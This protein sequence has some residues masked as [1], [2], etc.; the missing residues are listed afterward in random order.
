M[1]VCVYCGSSSGRAEYLAAARR[2]GET[3]ARRG[4]EVVYGGARVGTM[5]AVA[6]GALAA[7]GRVIGVIPRSLVDWE[8]AHDG[9][10]ELRVVDTPHERKAVMTGLADAVLAL[11]G[12]AGTFDELFEAWTWAQLKLHAKPVGALN[13]A[14]Y[15]D[16]L[17]A[18]VE[19][20]LREGFLKPPYRDMLLVDDDLERLLD[21]FAD[22]RP[23]DYT[24]SDDPP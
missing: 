17:V 6:D 4:A 3:L 18:L 14:G 21:R 24:W 12:G 22:Y 13:V 7:G 11:P 16:P 9:L 5:G 1:R 19:H 10:T 20:M 23:P 8:V 2:V 15:F